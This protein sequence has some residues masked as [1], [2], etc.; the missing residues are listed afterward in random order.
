M[1]GRSTVRTGLAIV[2][3]VALVAL[4]A[5]D[6]E[7]Y[8]HETVAGD[9]LKKIDVG[10]RHREYLLHLPSGYATTR[11]MPLL[12]VFHGSSA[13]ASVIER[14][15][16]FDEI[17][18]SLGLI[19]VYPEGL[20]RG[21]NIGECCRYSFM[22]HVSEIA[23]VTALL[24]HL[25][26]GLSVDPTRVYATGYSDGGTLSF[27][28]GCSLST[29]ITAVAAVSATL[30]DP[31]PACR[32]SR[33]VPVAII[34]GTGDTHIPYGGQPGAKASVRAKHLTLSS[35]Q[36]VQFWVDRNRCSEPPRTTRAGRVVRS[37]YECPDSAS[38]LFYSIVGGEH[39]WPGGGR[40]WIFSPLPPNDMNA[41]DSITS[42]FLRQ[43]LS[44]HAQH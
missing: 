14:E 40:G 31:L 16:A 20:H 7:Y 18:D 6:P 5:S 26:V 34:H 2:L 19:V 9:Y 43:R 25:E 1:A 21:W 37:V 3:A 12:F 24:D 23:F 28:L 13:S 41:T 15:T 4:V 36:V 35:P 10:G 11:P 8:T 29:R 17:A 38:V 42:F 39:G 44:P 32:I 22:K 27:L 30:F 33:S